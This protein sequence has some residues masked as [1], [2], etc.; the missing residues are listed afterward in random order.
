MKLTIG[1]ATYDDFDGVYFT[2][3]NIR[4]QAWD[5][6]DEIDLVVIDNNP[7]SKQGE[8]TKLFCQSANIRY[9]EEKRKQSTSVRNRVFTEAEAPVAMCIDSHVLI[10]KESIYKLLDSAKSLADDKNLYHGPMLYDYLDPDATPVT[11]M[12]PIWQDN[13]FGVWAHDVRGSNPDNAPFPIPMHGMGLFLS[14]VK[15]FQKFHE[16]FKGFGGEEGYIHEKT[17]LAGGDII[18]LPWLRWMHRFQRPNK[19]PYSNVI[20]DRIVNYLI[21]F[22]EV[23]WNKNTVVNHFKTNFPDIDYPTLVNATEEMLEAYHEDPEEVLKLRFNKTKETKTWHNTLVKL[24]TPLELELM[25][26]EILVKAFGFEY[27]LD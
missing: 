19:A 1:M 14:S 27:S 8:A 20:Q 9:L 5:R 21:G 13:M 17:R 6:I 24:D 10:E 18:C 7:T 15:H 25:G 16:L 2:C 4:F 26:K 12:D 22:S 23:G 11:H 3:N